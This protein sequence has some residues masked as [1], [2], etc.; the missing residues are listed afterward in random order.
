MPD[1]ICQARARNIFSICSSVM[2]ESPFPADRHWRMPL[3]TILKPAGPGPGYRR[4]LGDHL[5]AV[6]PGLDHGN[7]PGQLALRAPEPVE[8][9]AHCVVVDLHQLPPWGSFQNTLEGIPGWRA[10]A[11]ARRA[12]GRQRDRPDQC[13]PGGPGGTRAARGRAPSLR[14]GPEPGP[15]P[16]ALR[17]ACAPPPRPPPAPRPRPRPAC[18][19]APPGPRPARAPPAP[20]PPPRP[21]RAPP[22]LASRGPCAPPAPRP[23]F[24]RPCASACP[25]TNLRPADAPHQ[26]HTPHP[27]RGRV[28]DQP[29]G[30][31]I[32][33]HSLITNRFCAGGRGQQ[34][35]HHRY[36]MRTR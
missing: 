12:S 31:A 25:R 30:V 6:P 22:A 7:D 4:E 17:P 27:A 1:R 10:G 26:S 29:I 24:A 14:P 11:G 19:C 28:R 3:A 20:R 18:P 21:A 13:R 23:P 36:G 32:T 16:P 2:G 35:H 34:A 33:T 8:H 5:G 15:P 9:L